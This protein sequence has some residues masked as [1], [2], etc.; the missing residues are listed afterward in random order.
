[1]LYIKPDYFDQFKCTAHACEAT[2]CAGWQIVIDEDS[3]KRYEKE[4]G[5][6][7]EVLRS[8]IDWQ[9]GVFKQDACKRC[10]F[11]DQ[12]NL[13]D[14]YRNLGK[15]SLCRTCTN[16]PRHIEEFE[17]VREITLSLSCPE[18]ARIL[19]QIK[20]PVTFTESWEE[21]AEEE[22][23]DFDPFFYSYLEEGR[24]LILRILQNRT[25]D[26]GVRYGLV[27]RLAEEMQ[28]LVDCD[29]LHELA[30]LYE[31][32]EDG[33][34]LERATEAL[35][36]E[37]Q[38]FQENA[39]EAMA[40]SKAMFGK[41][42]E[43]EHLDDHWEPWLEQCW[44]LLY[45]NKARG[46]RQNHAAFSESFSVD[47]ILEQLTVYFIFTYFC[48][49]VYDGNVYG[50]VHMALVSVYILYEMFVAKWIEQ[51]QQISQ[52]DIERIV[53]RYSRELEHSDEN[54]EAMDEKFC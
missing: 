29:E 37:I 27:W 9:E 26:I 30:D 17:N 34:Y 10:A 16:Y 43:L 7:R 5:T 50:K 41:L 48:G 44:T 45:G 46:Y 35:Q 28:E 53:Y 49:A 14:M 18:V 20:E 51:E 24:K 36:K 3:L 25:L 6:Y 2:C 47:I 31:K 23:E 52:K 15:E 38:A 13:C 42:Y 21:D 19:L 8:R 33:A 11:L 1:M 39:S 12:D 32:Y 22:F 54:L 4:K 40:F